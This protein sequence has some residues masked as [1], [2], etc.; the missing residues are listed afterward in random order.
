[1]QTAA[2]SLPVSLD[3]LLDGRPRFAEILRRQLPP[4]PRNTRPPVSGTRLGPIEALVDRQVY[5]PSLPLFIRRC[6]GY[7]FQ[8]LYHLADHSPK[9]VCVDDTRERPALLK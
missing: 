3:G 1:M 2:R 9:L 5:D 8:I 4:P 6:P 7:Q